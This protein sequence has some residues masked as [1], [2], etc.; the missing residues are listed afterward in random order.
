MSNDG[1]Y[2]TQLLNRDKIFIGQAPECFKFGPYLKA[3]LSMSIDQLSKIRGS[4][5][6]AFMH[7]LSIKLVPGDE[8]NFK[9]TTMA[10]LNY[11]KNMMTD[12]S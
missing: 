1:Q 9:I 6:L 12:E 2:I 3:H 8:R 11:F 5:E 7:G 4:S 10:D